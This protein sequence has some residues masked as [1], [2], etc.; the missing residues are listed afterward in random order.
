MLGFKYS[1]FPVGLKLDGRYFYVLKAD[2]PADPSQ[3]RKKGKKKNKTFFAVIVDLFQGFTDMKT[4]DLGKS[5]IY[6]LPCGFAGCIMDSQD[7][8][9]FFHG[10]WDNREVT[11]DSSGAPSCLFPD[12]AFF[13]IFQ[14]LFVNCSQFPEAL[15]QHLGKELMASAFPVIFFF[16]DR[17]GPMGC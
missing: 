4:K 11:G 6:Y 5:I 14:Y 1:L 8:W 12:P 13:L 3:L 10:T 9:G 15:Q 16:A 7:R 17:L 2:S